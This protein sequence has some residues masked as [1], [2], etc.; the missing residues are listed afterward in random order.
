MRL[1]FQAVAESADEVGDL[2]FAAQL[3]FGPFVEALPP[4][5]PWRSG[6]ARDQMHVQMGHCVTDDGRV[7]VLGPRHVP[8]GTAGLRALPAHVPRLR[9][10]QVSQPGGVAARLHDQLP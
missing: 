2:P 8:Q 10:G 3:G 7:H 5:L 4:E 1:L 9:I 6:V